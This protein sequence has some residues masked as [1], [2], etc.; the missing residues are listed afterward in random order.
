MC[1][2]H[3]GHGI[4]C[5]LCQCWLRIVFVNFDIRLYHK[6]GISSEHRCAFIG[7]NCCTYFSAH[8]CMHDDV[9]FM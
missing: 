5:D 4:L 7:F 9:I 8:F 2:L 1:N 3:V 6:F